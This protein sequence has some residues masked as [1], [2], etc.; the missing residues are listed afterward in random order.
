MIKYFVKTMQGR[1]IGIIFIVLTVSLVIS[2][3]TILNVSQQAINLEKETKLLQ[4]ATHL[5]NQLGDVTYNDILA[6]QNAQQATRD[7]KIKVLNRMLRDRTDELASIFRGLGT[8]YYSLELDAILTYGPSEEYGNTVGVSISSDHPGR[9]AMS[10]A[11][12]LVRI[13]SMVRGDIMNAMVPL[14][15]QG[16]VIGYTWANELTSDIQNDYRRFSVNVFVLSFLVFLVAISVS[17]LLSRRIM[18]NMDTIIAGVKTMRNDLTK[19]IPVIKGD[20]SEVSES[21]NNMADDLAKNAKEHEAFLLAKAA[22][23]AQR[24]F[25]ARMSH[26][27]RTPMNGVLGMAM[28]ALKA[29]T[30][31]KSMEYLQ[32]I[33]SSATLLLGIINDILDFSKIEA[34]KLQLE[35]HPFKLRQ[36][37]YDLLEL[38]EPRIAEKGLSLQVAIDD[39][40]PAMAIGDGL[41]LSQVLLN[42]LGNAVKFSDEGQITL[43]V[44]AAEAENARFKLTCAITDTGIGMSESQIANLFQPFSQADNSMARKY[45]G[46]GL[47]LSICRA[48][49]HLMGGSISVQSKMR[50]GSTFTFHVWLQMCGDTDGLVVTAPGDMSLLRY[51]GLTAL[52]AEDIEINQEIAVAVLSEF[53]FACDVAENGQTAVQM[54][55]QKPYDVIFMDIRMPIMDGLEA[56]RTIR[57]LEAESGGHAHIPIIAMTA[58]AMQEDRDLSLQAGMDAHVSKPIDMAE[59]QA[60]LYQVVY[61]SRQRQ[62]ADQHDSQPKTE[63]ED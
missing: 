18:R 41:K 30:Q 36:A 40:V 57:R 56:T 29:E 47:G 21:I 1:I 9:E 49:I 10:K 60:V 19:R 6:S 33:Q 44:S 62:K 54:Y 61:M 2:L 52:L 5:G 58:N 15:R 12:P 43:S 22:N 17:I 37:I 32:K 42:L 28:L 51:S 14:E 39:S 20:L 3:L 35:S 59:I 16:E 4:I 7:E 31:E 23:L 24:D 53:G 25:L 26:E 27:L 38:L 55:Q 63:A 45:G 48:L 8:G 46:T 11:T 34:N 13:G 50:E